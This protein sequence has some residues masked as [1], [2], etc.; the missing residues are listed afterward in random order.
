[1]RIKEAYS[2]DKHGLGYAMEYEI[3]GK[4]HSVT[5]EFHYNKKAGR[6]EHVHVGPRG[7]E[8]LIYWKK[9]F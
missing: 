3:S 6:F 4:W 9:K 2:F 8:T 5:G 1:M 7:G